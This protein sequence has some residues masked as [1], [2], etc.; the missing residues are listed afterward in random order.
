MKAGIGYSKPQHCYCKLYSLD[1][2]TGLPDQ[3]HHCTFISKPVSV[4]F[5]SPWILMYFK[6]NYSLSKKCE[7]ALSVKSLLFTTEGASG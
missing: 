6:A 7:K 1:L 2:E 4:Q 3:P 5:I